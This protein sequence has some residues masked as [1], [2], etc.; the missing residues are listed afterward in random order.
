MVENNK[1]QEQEKVQA[2]AA[3]DEIEKRVTELVNPT[4]EKIEEYSKPGAFKKLFEE[5]T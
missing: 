4:P 3:L 1:K 2:K 5:G